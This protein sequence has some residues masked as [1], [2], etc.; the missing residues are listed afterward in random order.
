[1]LAVVLVL[2]PITEQI[3]VEG[4]VANAA[5]MEIF[6]HMSTVELEVHF[7]AVGTVLEREVRCCYGVDHVRIHNNTTGG[8]ILE[9]STSGSWR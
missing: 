2:Q 7:N 6:R 3:D 5:V 4:D 8:G 1:M 9:N